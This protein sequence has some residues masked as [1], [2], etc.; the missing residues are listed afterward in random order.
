MKLSNYNLIV[1]DKN[2]EDYYLFNTFIGSCFKINNITAEAIKNNCIEDINEETKELFEMSGIIIPDKMNESNIFSYLREKEKYNSD[3]LSVTLLLTW[4]C[5]LRCIY[6]F[7]EHEVIL[8]DMD[9]NQANRFLSFIVNTA[10][11][12]KAKGIHITLFGGEPLMNMKIGYEILHIIKDFCEKNK[13]QFS[14]GLITNG[15]LINNE[16]LEKMYSHNCKMI[17]ITLD[18]VKKIHD[19]RRI[20]SNGKGSFEE[21]ITALQL[22][23]MKNTIH[24]VIRINIDK[25]NVD[26]L[27]DLLYQ[28]GKDGLNLT[29]CTVDFGIVRAETKA[30][31]GYSSN[32]FIESE[33]G[34]IIYDLW[35]Y[36]EK[37]GFKYNIKPIRRYLY[38]GL[39]GNNQYTIAPN[40]DVF[41]CWEHV[42]QEEH[43]MGK[44]DEYG[45]IMQPTNSFY[46]WMSVDPLKNIECKNCIYLPNCGGGCGV[47]SF[48]ESGTYHAKGCFRVKGTVE[49]QVLKF[50]ENSIKAS[51]DE[52]NEKNSCSDCK[53]G[54]NSNGKKEK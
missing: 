48:N 22:L 13:L 34:D 40:C 27:Y 14:C 11:N 5:N 28:I 1:S 3:F 15:T 53:K 44:L 38:C 30:C 23:N 54:S 4:N 18:G 25:R 36:A 41:K 51:M 19:T 35:N 42:G 16:T 45:R 50:V 24:T 10:I 43:L 47:I 21:T 2:S 29:K 20:Y 17:Q 52:V 12:N 6:C 31:A 37:Q 9:E 39:Y 49:K 7:Q 46:E 8:G 32:C 33:I 26:D